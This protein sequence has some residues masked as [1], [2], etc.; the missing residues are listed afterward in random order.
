[1][2]TQNQVMARPRKKHVQQELAWRTHGGKRAGAGRPPKGARAGQPHTR[3]PEHKARNPV[4]I[5]IRAADVVGSLRKRDMYLAVR[6]A[7]IT[8]ARR[9]DFRIVHASVQGDHIHLIVEARSKDAI[10]RGMRGFEISA[11]MRINNAITRRTGKRRRGSVFSDR[12]HLRALTSPRA[13]KHALAYVLNNWRKHREDRA[14]LPSTWK[15]DPFSSGVGFGGWRELAGAMTLYRPP[16]T[17]QALFVWL[18]KTW[19]LR[20]GWT[21]HGL[22]STHEVPGPRVAGL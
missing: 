1:M 3:R 19:L 20:E 21:R 18:P 15:I 14:G 8:T 10:S 7:S 5:T 16:P 12:Y 22:I 11:A 2:G 6:D 13:V 9:D 4:Q 17:Y